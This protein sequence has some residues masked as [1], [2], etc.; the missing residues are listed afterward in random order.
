MSREFQSDDLIERTL[1]IWQRCSEQPLDVEN[2]REIIA[3]VAG[4]FTLLSQWEA[5]REARLGHN[6]HDKRGRNGRLG[7]E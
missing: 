4:F 1:Q 5:E 7:P 6:H 2:A 3:N